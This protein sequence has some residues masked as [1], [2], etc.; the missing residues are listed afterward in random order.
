MPE[1]KEWVLFKE[2]AEGTIVMLQGLLSQATSGN[3]AGEIV[4]PIALKYAKQLA[5]TLS[6][7]L[8]I[9]PV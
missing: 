3:P 6:A 7:L 2:K 8:A 4:K 1:S 5:D 9:P